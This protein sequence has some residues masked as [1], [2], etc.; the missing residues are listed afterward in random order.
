MTDPRNLLSF[1]GVG[2]SMDLPNAVM[3][4]VLSPLPERD[5]VYRNFL[6]EFGHDAGRDWFRELYEAELAE[7]K[8]KGQDFTAPEVSEL[9][10]ELA[11]A[12][13]SMHEPTAGTGG[14]LVAAWNRARMSVLP[15][16]FFPSRHMVDCWE[17]SDRSVPILLFN[18]SI[19]G[20]M[21]YIHHG[22]VLEQKAVMHYVLL[23]RSDDALGFSEVIKDPEGRMWIVQDIQ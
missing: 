3:R 8:Q 12:D 4:V 14:L 19:R 15:W 17:L 1:F 9:L 11:E 7:R 23:N 10:A 6:A 22:D 5:T 21:G 16:E 13:G 2:D 18:L 20:I